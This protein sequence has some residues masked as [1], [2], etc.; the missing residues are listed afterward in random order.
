M[1]GGLGQ[2]ICVWQITVIDQPL[3]V[4][5]PQT[6]DAV[7]IDARMWRRRQRCQAADANSFCPTHLPLAPGQRR[8]LKMGDRCGVTCCGLGLF[9]FLICY[10]TGLA[11]GCPQPASPARDL[12]VESVNDMNLLVA[13]G[14]NDLLFHAVEGAAWRTVCQTL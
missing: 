2:K 9:H 12:R 3:D 13:A 5:D 10:E 1:T 8:Q 7:G 4:V 11:F 6:K 14:M